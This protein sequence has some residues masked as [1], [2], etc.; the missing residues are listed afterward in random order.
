M[1]TLYDRKFLV[2]IIYEKDIFAIWAGVLVGSI[3]RCVELNNDCVNDMGIFKVNTFAS[4]SPINATE[5]YLTG[6]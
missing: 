1:A 4:R 2:N 5:S 3:F 6:S